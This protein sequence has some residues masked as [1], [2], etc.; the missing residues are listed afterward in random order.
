MLL[1][2]PAENLRLVLSHMQSMGG[3]SAVSFLSMVYETHTLDELVSRLLENQTEFLSTGDLPFISVGLEYSRFPAC[4]AAADMI[5]QIATEQFANHPGLLPHEILPRSRLPRRALSQL[6][7]R[8]ERPEHIQFH[9]RGAIISPPEFEADQLEE[10]Q[11]DFLPL[12]LGSLWRT[13][14]HDFDNL[15]LID[16][17][18]SGRSFFC[19]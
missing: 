5:K 18:V 7:N 19:K 6:L 9:R 14:Q 15:R 16:Q 1:F 13:G 12:P 10:E 17:Q 8:S 2:Q 4:V 11:E 3:D